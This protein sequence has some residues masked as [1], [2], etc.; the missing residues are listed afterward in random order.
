MFS[1]VLSKLVVSN[2]THLALVSRGAAHFLVISEVDNKMCMGGNVRQ[3]LHARATNR[4]L[5]LV[6]ATDAEVAEL[7]AMG[8]LYQKG[9]RAMLLSTSAVVC[10]LASRCGAFLLRVSCLN[11]IRFPEAAHSI[12]EA[13]VLRFPAESHVVRHRRAFELG[14]LKVAKVPC[15]LVAFH[16]LQ[17][18]RLAEDIEAYACTWPLEAQAVCDATLTRMQQA[19]AVRKKANR[20]SKVWMDLTADLDSDSEC[21]PDLTGESLL[22]AGRSF[23]FV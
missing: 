4:K 16:M 18:G 21:E 23:L 1:S 15:A 13:L 7:K 6:P 12:C 8:S 14:K 5:H 3:Y 9:Y 22:P 17:G 19:A 20:S 11:S 10:A 2:R